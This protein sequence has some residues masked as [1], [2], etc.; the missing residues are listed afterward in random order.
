MTGRLQV[1]ALLGVV[2]LFTAAN[3]TGPRGVSVQL[4]AANNPTLM[5]D[6]DGQDA[7][8]VSVTKDGQIF[9]GAETTA[10]DVLAAKVK[11]RLSAGSEKMV[12]VKADG[13]AQYDTV[14]KVFDDLRTAGVA[15]L[16]LLV[17]RRNPGRI[18]VGTT[19]NGRRS[20]R[21]AYR[22]AKAWP[23]HDCRAGS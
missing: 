21:S 10:S 9:L 19:G 20:R 16:G 6:A 1:V 7:V 23:A 11:D 8:I 4:A 2:A 13:R 5:P 12:Y 17:Q 14:I 18:F 22:A 15:D 3:C